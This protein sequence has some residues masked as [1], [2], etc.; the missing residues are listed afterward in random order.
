MLNRSL[1]LYFREISPSFS[2]VPASL[3]RAR[4]KWRRQ[5]MIG[6][7]SGIL[8]TAALAQTASTYVQTSIVSDGSVPAAVTDSTLIN[9]WGV[10]V[11]P[12]I[13]ID[14][15]GS[16]AVAVDTSAGAPVIPAV[17]IPAASGTGNGSPTGTVYN[18]NSA[19]FI[20]PES[21]ASASF[22]FATLD[23]TIA[24][25]T[26]G[27]Q[28]VTVVNNSAAKARYTGLALDTGTA[29][30][31]LLAAD[32]GLGTVDVF[33]TAFQKTAL[34]G[35]FTDPSLPAGYAP[36]GI[37][38]LGGMVYVTYTQVNPSSGG[39]MAGAGVGYVDQFDSNGNF[40]QRV[41]S[42]SVLNAP[43]GMAIA[44]AGFGSYAN[45][46]LIGNFGDGVINVFNPTTFALIGSL[47]NSAGTSIA[48][49][50]LWEIFVGQGGTLGDPNTL[51]FAAGINGQKDGLFGSIAVPAPAAGA[52]NFS[53]SAASPTLSV[54]GGQTGSLTLSLAPTNGFN[55]P[56]TFSCSGLPSGASCLF[57]PASVNL[58]GSTSVSVSL[59][60][61]TTPL[62]PVAPPVGGGGTGGY[63]RSAATPMHLFH[64]SAGLSLAF[65]GPI[66][67]LAFVGLKRKSVRGILVRG[68]LAALL[69]GMAMGAVAGCSSSANSMASG[70]AA[71]T[72]VASQITIN[73][74][75]ASVTQ[76]VTVNLTVM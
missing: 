16:G 7:M 15:T 41:A 36:F 26:S 44:P 71:A 29:G 3:N 57:T 34:A 75:S 67:L 5:L 33:N 73:A 40:L 66:G 31:F 12:A 76:S 51:Y 58:S 49:P 70:S 8:S 13:W 17:S 42:Q 20:V 28:A 38:S 37:H 6:A 69:L 4:N 63:L 19:I 54:T 32:F 52:P 27:T 48:N 30:T 45:D 9:P 25:W 60:L 1:L 56:V 68:S 22:L 43:W 18:S 59:A 64:S 35:G 24:G 61:A 55:G 11:G 65:A 72:P 53:F 62:A 14:K 39:Y 23:G 21:N 10:S 74:T 47:Q 46:L 2:R 50:G